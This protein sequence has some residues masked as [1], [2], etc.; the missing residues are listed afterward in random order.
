MISNEAAPSLAFKMVIFCLRY[1]GCDVRSI[2]RALKSY[3]FADTTESVVEYIKEEKLIKHVDE[4]WHPNNERVIHTVPMGSIETGVKVAI[5]YGGMLP[6][7]MKVKYWQLPDLIPYKD[8]I[9]HA[10][11][12]RKISTSVTRGQVSCR[13]IE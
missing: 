1:Y 5:E 4:Q 10:A 13:C 2:I 7:M 8:V 12:G 6:V 11:D 9:V 3:R